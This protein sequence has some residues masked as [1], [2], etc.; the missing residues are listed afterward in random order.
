[1]SRR[2]YPATARNRDPIL[3][4]LQ[5]VLPSRGLLLE[6]ASGSGEHAVHFA[7]HLPD[8]V[9][10]PTDPAA[11]ARESIEAWRVHEGRPNV[12]PPLALDAAA[13]TWPVEAAEAVLCVN[14]VHISPWAAT[15]GLLEG[16]ARIL[17]PGG[18]LVLYGPYRIGGAHTAPSNASFDASLRARDPRWGV[19]DLERVLEEAAAR[20]LAHEE[21]VPMPA[22]NQTVVLRVGSSPG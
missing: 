20:G 18:P 7:A 22:N 12:R 14:M 2:F 3:A 19:R 11:E 5:R 4:V 8:L 10:Q 16:A 9:F 17:P 6:V 13:S 21:T 1:M 15:L